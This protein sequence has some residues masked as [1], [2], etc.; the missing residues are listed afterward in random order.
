ME[1][2]CLAHGQG[3]RLQTWSVGIQTGS[4]HSFSLRE[5][6]MLKCEV[7]GV[8]STS[9][10]LSW[11]V[12]TGSSPW[13]RQMQFILHWTHSEVHMLDMRGTTNAVTSL[14]TCTC[15]MWKLSVLTSASASSATRFH[16]LTDM[17]FYRTIFGK[18]ETL[19]L[20]SRLFPWKDIQT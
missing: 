17:C 19:W 11:P 7:R 4:T 8:F 18:Q 12:A 10:S 2:C 20:P 3:R 5:T 9:S 6:L 16:T 13:Q 1:K 14:M 15:N